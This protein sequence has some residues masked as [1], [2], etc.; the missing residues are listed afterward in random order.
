MISLIYKVDIG[1]GLVCGICS[2]RVEIA[3]SVWNN[4]HDATDYLKIF[5]DKD[6]FKKS[7]ERKNSKQ[8]NK[9]REKAEKVKPD[10]VFECGVCSKSFD[11][12]ENLDKHMTIH[13]G[14]DFAANNSLAESSNLSL[15]LSPASSVR[16]SSIH[17]R[18]AS[19]TQKQ[20]TCS[21]SPPSNH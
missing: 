19:N 15:Q 1:S 16:R 21:Q 4:I 12:M 7:V 5:K 6:N 14:K 11:N 17:L 2:K 8:Q 13:N 9:K 10:T 20:S 18:S 3:W